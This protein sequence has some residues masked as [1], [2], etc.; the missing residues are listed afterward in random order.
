[1]DKIKINK[2]MAP[3]SFQIA[4]TGAVYTFRI[5]YNAYADMFTVSLY[6]D[7]E[8]ICSG[9]PIMY[10]VPLFSDIYM[11]EVFPAITVVPWDESGRED[12]VTWDNFEETVFLRIE[13]GG[14]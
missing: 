10:G 9:E 12:K 13:N 3:Y 4:L 6:K 11:A 8:L 1:M 5:D 7:G 14:A 2:K